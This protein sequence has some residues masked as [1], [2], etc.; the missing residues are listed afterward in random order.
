MGGIF[1]TLFAKIAAV[2][3]WFADLFVAIFQAIWHVLTDLVC[4]SFESALGIVFTAVDAIDVSGFSTAIGSFSQLPAEIL[5]I[6][7]LLGFGEAMTIIGAALLI[8]FGLQL[9][10]FVRLGS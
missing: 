9:I 4:W 8:R 7:M 10:P 5:N 1:T 3:K 2:V 6:L